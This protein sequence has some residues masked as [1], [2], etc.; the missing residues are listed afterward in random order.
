[1]PS[2]MASP[3]ATESSTTFTLTENLLRPALTEAGKILP[4]NINAII[5]G[6]AARDGIIYDIY[7]DRKSAP[8][9]PDRSRQNIA[10]KHQCHHR[11]LRRT[12]RNHLR[13]LP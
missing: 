5:D 13:H 9:C 8:P 2:S 10:Q 7:P 4:R 1:M 3:H 12:R 11:W 6:F